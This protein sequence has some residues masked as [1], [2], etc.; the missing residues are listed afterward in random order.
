MLFGR[1]RRKLCVD[2]WYRE[3]IKM[4]LE[5]SDYSAARNG[6]EETWGTA[7]FI[8]LQWNRLIFVDVLDNPYF[9]AKWALKFFN[10]YQIAQLPQIALVL[11]SQHQTSEERRGSY[12]QKLSI[13]LTGKWTSGAGKGQI[14]CWTGIIIW[15]TQKLCGDNSKGSMFWNFLLQYSD[16][17]YYKASSTSWVMT[18]WFLL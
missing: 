14:Q 6:E 17:L 5:P 9:V 11:Q 8:W 2:S 15:K 4:S 13:R 12:R 7:Y 10:D 3:G 18:E 1:V 16:T